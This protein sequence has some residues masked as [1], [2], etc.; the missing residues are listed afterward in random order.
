MKN[1]IKICARLGCKLAPGTLSVYLYTGFRL[2]LV[3]R[4]ISGTE[5]SCIKYI[6][7]CLRL[8]D[9]LGEIGVQKS[10]QSI[11]SLSVHSILMKFGHK[12][13]LGCRTQVCIGMPVKIFGSNGSYCLQGEIGVQTCTE[14]LSSYL[15]TR[16]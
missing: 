1:Y 6:K 10:T 12:L 9:L 16:F 7:I 13:H 5:Q 3:T 4:F 15:Y 2:H 11:I 8:A 14:Y